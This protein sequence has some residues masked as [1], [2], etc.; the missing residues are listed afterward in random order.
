ML[1]RAELEVLLQQQNRHGSAPCRNPWPP[2]FCES[3]ADFKSDLRPIQGCPHWPIRRV[4]T[5]TT[6]IDYFYRLL[7]STTFI[8]TTCLLRRR[9]PGQKIADVPF[10]L[11]MTI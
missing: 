1:H 2:V 11:H 3:V 7:L 9:R 4:K 8:G 5:T 10:G 6:Y